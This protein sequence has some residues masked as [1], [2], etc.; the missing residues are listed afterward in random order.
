MGKF[1]NLSN[2]SITSAF[3]FHVIFI[4]YKA[5]HNHKPFSVAQNDNPQ[6]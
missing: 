5:S 2:A 3:E 4:F 6:A 1:E